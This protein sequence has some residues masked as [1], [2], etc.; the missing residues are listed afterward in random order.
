MSITDFS[1]PEEM[2]IQRGQHLRLHGYP[3]LPQQL[4]RMHTY[5]PQEHNGAAS[6]SVPGVLPPSI[7]LAG[8]WMPK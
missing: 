3:L 6:V 8:F 5:T 1:V 4:N 7:V 2:G